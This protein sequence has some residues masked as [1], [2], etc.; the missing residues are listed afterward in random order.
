MIL[1]PAQGVVQEITGGL[2]GQGFGGSWGFVKGQIARSIVEDIGR[3][4][5]DLYG[6]RLRVDTLELISSIQAFAPPTLDALPVRVV[7]LGQTNSGKS[8]LV[9]AILGEVKAAVSELPTPGGFVE[10][11]LQTPGKPDLILVDAPGL[12]GDGIGQEAM[13]EAANESDLVLWVASAT[14]PARR[15]DQDALQALQERFDSQPNRKSPPILI[16]VTHV[17]RL[18]P[19]REWAPPYNVEKPTQGKAVSIRAAIDVI[20]S[21]LP[22]ARG[23][24]VPVALRKGEP[25]YNLDALW[26]AMNLL[27]DDAR[28]TALD[29]ALKSHPGFSFSQVSTQCVEGG[30]FVGGLVLDGAK[31]WWRNST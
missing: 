20:S 28:H 29:R 23:L 27:L 31:R 1:N 16:V 6:G 22:Q 12:D 10:F 26:V 17:D 14:N 11:R 2:Q 19:Q 15:L 4:A 5:I 18:S 21:A 8:S 13:I 9:N 7:V 3:S 30:R 25:G 24:A